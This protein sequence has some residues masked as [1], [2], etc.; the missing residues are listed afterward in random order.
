M[1]IYSPDRMLRPWIGGSAKFGGRANFLKEN[2]D[3][4]LKFSVDII[5]WEA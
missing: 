2:K 4:F 1:I 3:F 5:S